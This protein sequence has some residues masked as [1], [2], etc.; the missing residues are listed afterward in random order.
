MW[1]FNYNKAVMAHQPWVHGLQP[2]AIE[3]VFQDMISVWVD[4]IVP[5]EPT[6]NK[7]AD[8]CGRGGLRPRPCPWPETA[9]TEEFAP[10]VSKEGGMFAYAVRRLLQFIPTLLVI[11]LIIFLLSTCC[12]VTPP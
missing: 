6:K 3:M 5:P 1:F 4:D 9:S 12:P 11:T 10:A 8:T 7:P 2:V